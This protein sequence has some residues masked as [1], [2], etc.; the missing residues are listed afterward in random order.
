MKHRRAQ[1]DQCGR[2]QDHGILPG[3]AEQQ[4]AE[5]GR[6]HA[7][8]KRER[9]RLLVG[10]MPDQRLQ[11]RRGELERQRDHADLG[12]VERIAR[13]QERI[14]RGNQRLHGVVEE[15]READAGEHDIGRSRGSPRR[16]DCRDVR[17]DDRPSQNFFG[18]QTLLGD[19]DRLVQR[20]IPA[21]FARQIRGATAMS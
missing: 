20:I 4:Q 15:V 5:E 14:D 2:N 6:S 21:R 16:R 19:N 8:R 9:L 10:E 17:Q 13:F 7:D 11:Q 12:E 18:D 3:H 1:S